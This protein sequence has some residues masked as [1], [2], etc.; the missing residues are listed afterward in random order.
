MDLGEGVGGGGY[1]QRDKGN[2]LRKR[3]TFG[4]S[5]RLAAQAKLLGERGGRIPGGRGGVR[6]KHDKIRKTSKKGLSS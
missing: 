4:A 6:M 5:P 1:L 2:C 3:G